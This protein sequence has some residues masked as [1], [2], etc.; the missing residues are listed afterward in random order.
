MSEH[1]LIELEIK[2]S[3]Q[4]DLLDTLNTIVARQQ[5]QL[6][7]LQQELRWLYQQGLAEPAH[8]SQPPS[9]RDEI[10]PHY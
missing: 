3:L 8:G 7:L 9:L 1:R 6:D 5:A 4:E 10:P 2:L